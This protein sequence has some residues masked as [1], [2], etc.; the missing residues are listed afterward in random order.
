MHNNTEALILDIPDKELGFT[1]YLTFPDGLLPRGII[2]MCPL[3]NKLMD[4]LP[5]E[6]VS[7]YTGKGFAVGEVHPLKDK[8]GKTDIQ[9][10]VIGYSALIDK[11][12]G[13]YKYLP[14]IAIGSTLS[15]VAVRELAYRESERLGGVVLIEPTIPMPSKFTMY[16]AGLISFIEG[17][18]YRSDILGEYGLTLHSTISYIKKAKELNS[19]DSINNYPKHMPTLILNAED[20]ALFEALDNAYVSEVEKALCSG[21]AEQ[22]E[23]IISFIDSVIDGVNDA[24]SSDSFIYRGTDI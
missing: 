3:P 12:R 18:E 20:D 5:D 23:R 14:I 17:K 10:M 13:K 16:R 19:A 6:I 8:K 22:T 15:T 2:L 9:S 1:G 4:K 11:I 21:K 24:L 7:T